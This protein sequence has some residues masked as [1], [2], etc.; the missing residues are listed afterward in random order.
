MSTLEVKPPYATGDPGRTTWVYA[1][2]AKASA[3]CKTT[4][5]AI[6]T[7]A[8]APAKVNGVI[9]MSWFRADISWM[10]WSITV[11]Y[12]SGVLALMTE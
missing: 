4:A 12:R 5:P 8:I 11:S 2:P 3:F 1:I 10:P 9:M 6:V 7:G